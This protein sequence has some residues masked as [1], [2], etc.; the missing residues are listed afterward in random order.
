MSVTTRMSNRRP[1]EAASARKTSFRSEIQG[2]RALAVLLVF[3]DHLFLNPSGGFI[4]VDVF[5]VISGYLITGLL[6][7]EAEAKGRPSIREF[8]ARRVR[9]IIPVA[10]VVLVVTNLVAK[11][12]FT[13][14][15][16]TQTQ[17]DSIWALLFGANVH[18]SSIGTDYFQK[19]RPPSAVQHFWSLS[20]E[21]QFYVAW[22]LLIILAFVLAA[23]FG[24]QGNRIVF[25]LAVFGTIASFVWCVHLTN[26]NQTVAYFSTPARAWELGVGA[27]L[28]LSQST[29]SKLP[30]GA[31]ALAA[32][33]GL[34]AIAVSAVTYSD[35]TQF[36]GSA[37]A[38][39]VLGCGLL[40]AANNPER[41]PGKLGLLSNP[42][43]EYLGN[44]G[45]PDASVGV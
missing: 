16:A 17:T 44:I 24:R 25:P 27:V 38:L 14:F 19:G 33:S 5:F 41:G 2:L 43:A 12:V 7:R 35:S 39:P 6:V 28:A 22:P 13:P 21:E 10:V 45:S 11:L 40:L 36:P 26:A 1:S 37:A 42:V 8:Y 29:I 15:R 30:S 31:R 4:G 18:F 32:W 23:R 9:R 20:V 34:S 3:S